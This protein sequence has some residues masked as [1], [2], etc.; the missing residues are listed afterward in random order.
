M[1]PFVKCFTAVCVITVFLSCGCTKKQDTPVIPRDPNVAISCIGV[2]PVQPEI[3]YESSVSFALAKQLKEG[4]AIMD[5]LLRKRFAG[6]PEFRFASA[7]QSYGLENQ[8][9]HGSLEQLQQVAGQLSCDAILEARISRFS[10]RIGGEYTAKEPAAV[11]FEY[12][13]VEVREGRVLCQGTFDEMQQS[14]MENIYNWNRAK[15]RG[16]TW[17]TAEELLTEGVDEKFAQCSYLSTP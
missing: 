7:A 5:R 15:S 10:D 2:M 12:R 9:T 1:I 17:I 13:L 14:L 4:A 6:N 11:A 16:F 3:N 8:T